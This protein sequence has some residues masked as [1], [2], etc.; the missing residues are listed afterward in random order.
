MP[1]DASIA[2][3]VQPPQVTGPLDSMGKAMTLK[4][5]MLQGQV[6]EEQLAAA[7]RANL[8]QQKLSE[9]YQS[10]IGPDG[11]VNHAGVIQAMGAQGVGHLI[12]AY[13]KTMLDADKDQSAIDNQ[14]SEIKARDYKRTLDQVSAV[15]STLDSLRSLPNVTHQDII[16]AVVGMVQNGVMGQDQG[17]RIVQE[18][19]PHP[20]LLP[21]YL[22]QK[23][24]QVAD[25][26]TRLEMLAPKFQTL[27][28][29]GSIIMGT[30]NPMTG[31]FTQGSS[32][33]KVTTPGENLSAETQRRGQNL[34]FQTSSLGTE[35]TPTG[36][37]VINKVKGT[38]TPVVDAGGVPAQQEKS[39]L[40]ANTNRY[41]AIKTAITQ[42]RQ[43]LPDATA[44]GVG[45]FVD[46]GLALGGVALPGADAAAQLETLGGWMTSNVPRME[47]PQSDADAKIYKQM[48]GQ[49]ADRTMPTSVRIKALETLETLQDKYADQ[50]GVKS[51]LAKKSSARPPLS[52]F[53]GGK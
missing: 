24:L 44:S 16:Q 33:K 50:N 40:Q 14:R 9:I 36:I 41:T 51:F 21:G 52:A 17:Q 29:G 3:G 12:P 37:A 10:N 31:Q 34:T 5:L 25:S 45:A 18:L 19:P 38:S 47:G 27:D 11:M 26:K 32:I 28:N 8:E 30:T 22:A 2:M 4:H 13:R 1:I 48:A 23:G 46:K 43:L 42:A 53:M 20:A 15:N 49:V 7:R 35:H 39:P 6:Q